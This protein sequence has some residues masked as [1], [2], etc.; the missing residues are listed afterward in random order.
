MLYL[1]PPC[2]SPDPLTDSIIGTG[3]MNHSLEQLQVDLIES[4]QDSHYAA[5]A[6]FGTHL[7]CV[8]FNKLI[9]QPMFLAK[10]VVRLVV[11]QT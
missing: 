2:T 1:I 11:P 4:R 7:N 8:H 9:N 5:N 6:P 10:K 3:P